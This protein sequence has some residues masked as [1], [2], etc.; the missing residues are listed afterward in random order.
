MVL[1]P[2]GTFI[3]GDGVTHC[4]E[5]EREV[6]LTHSF[7]LGRYEVTNQEYVAA[8]QWA[9]DLGHVTV[10]S[11][12]VR[13]ALDDSKEK[14]LDLDGSECEIAFDEDSGTFSTVNAKCPVKHVTWYGAARYCDW[15]SLQQGFPRA[16][17][18]GGDWSCNGGD[19]YG[20]GGYRLPTDA[21]WE[22]AAQYED[23][24]IHP[25]G[26]ETP[27]CGRANYYGCLG[28]TSPV[29]SYPGA[30]DISGELLY[31]M[32]GNVW[33]WCNDWHECLL[34]TTPETDPVGPSSGASRVVRSGCWYAGDCALRCASRAASSHPGGDGIAMGF[35][36]ARS[37]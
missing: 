2:A 22:Y 8:V 33:E 1:V 32:A 6:T 30:P 14:L 15:L 34:G 36:C 7:Y 20:A 9:Y 27:D 28:S 19:P 10:D 5:E 23:E 16:Y 13:D 17:E 24:R 25:W 18:H 4:G 26:D 21:E 12:S 11:S 35:R 31:D 3:M 29:G 37:E